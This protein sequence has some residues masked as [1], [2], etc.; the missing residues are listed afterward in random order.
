M[1][2]FAKGD[3]LNGAARRSLEMQAM[4]KPRIRYLRAEEF[5][6]AFTAAVRAQ[7]TNALREKEA[8]IARLKGRD[9]HWP[10]A[11]SRWYGDPA[12]IEKAR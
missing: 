2:R 8:S 1:T 11:Q 6:T 12:R 5:V 9:S 3:L 7:H 10:G 4:A